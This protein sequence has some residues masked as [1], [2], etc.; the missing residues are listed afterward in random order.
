MEYV[1]WF[2]IKDVYLEMWV[3]K[4][5]IMFSGGEYVFIYVIF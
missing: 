2:C 3:E 1:F 5:N 4:S